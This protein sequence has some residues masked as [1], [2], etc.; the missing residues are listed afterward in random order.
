MSFLSKL[1]KAA[2]S[3]V[4]G[5]SALALGL[6]GVKA[7]ANLVGGETGK[8]INQGVEM[9]ENGLN[10][11]ETEKLSP[12]LKAEMLRE[13]NRHEEAMAK[14]AQEEG[15]LDLKAA[16]QTTKRAATLEGTAE[17]LKALPLIG[18]II[19]FFRGCQR[20]VWGFAVLWMDWAW[21]TDW[22]AL[23]EMQEVALVVI[24]GLVL[25]FL[26]G[27]RAVKNLMPLILR[28]LGPVVIDKKGK[29]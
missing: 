13:R 11:V 3:F 21:F 5:G 19:I 20:P 14:V 28:M 7:I 2:L 10:E 1:G 17:D 29:A 26:F 6:D 8:K 4:P 15:R 25:G 23:S 27:E 18:R 9:V 16:E 24:N 12:E 22:K